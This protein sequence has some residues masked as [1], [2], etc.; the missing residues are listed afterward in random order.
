MNKHTIV[1]LENMAN[2]DMNKNN[3]SAIMA[4]AVDNGRL[5]TLG[6]LST[7]PFQQDVHEA[8]LAT[9]ATA[10]NL[11]MVYSP[12]LPLI[13]GYNLDLKDNGMFFNEAEKP[14]GVKLL[15]RG[16]EIKITADG[17]SGTADVYVTAG[18]AEGKF[19]FASTA[20]STGFYAEVKSN[21]T[22]KQAGKYGT[23]ELP[24]YRL[25]VMAV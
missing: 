24:A 18:D 14:F 6:S 13:E 1:V 15:E 23:D 3:K 21:E 22:F 10:K 20:P 25:L 9:S 8:T 4:D 17:I 12:E 11:Y 19:K 2:T 7:D 16:D 5:V